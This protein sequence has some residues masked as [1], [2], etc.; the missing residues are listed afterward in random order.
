MNND[1]FV[2][3][4]KRLERFIFEYL[5]E[6]C[7]FSGLALLLILSILPRYEQSRL[8]THVAEVCSNLNHLVDALQLY[9]TENPKSKV[10]PP[11]N[12]E[13]GY[14]LCPIRDNTP[15]SLRFLTTP[16]S[17][18]E[19]IPTDPFLK[20]ASQEKQDQTP[21]VLHWVK[22]AGPSLDKPT[23]YLHIAW[24]ALSIGPSLRLPPQ[25]NL[26]VLRLVPYEV[27]PL[28]QN[29]YSPTNGLRSLGLLYHD[30][31]GNSSKL[32]PS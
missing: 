32:K 5:V 4:W 13:P 20:K 6:I 26:R 25:Y 22:I 30:S 28:T 23:D 10:F 31:L 16:S 19:K 15:F 11:K 18:L 21:V 2:T 17:Y 3:V 9:I 1:P 8:K 24:G 7:L 27:H 14:F 29:F 12:L